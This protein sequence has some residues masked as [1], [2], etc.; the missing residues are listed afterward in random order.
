MARVDTA[1]S[2]FRTIPNPPPLSPPRTGDKSNTGRAHPLSTSLPHPR[3]QVTQ[4]SVKS[5]SLA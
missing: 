5:T 2:C 4:A 1:M 3:M